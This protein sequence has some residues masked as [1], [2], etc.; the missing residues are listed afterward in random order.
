[1]LRKSG[2][3]AF[4]ILIAFLMV[5][6]A[7]ALGLGTNITIYD[8]ES[9]GSPGWH[10]QGTSPGEDEEVEPGN[11]TGQEWDLEG[12]FLN[13]TKL[14]MVGG[15]NFLTGAGGFRS[16]D[17]FID[18]D[19]DA[20]YGEDASGLVGGLNSKGNGIFPIT[21]VYG[22]DYVFDLDVASDKLDYDVYKLD[23]SSVLESVHYRI[24]DGANPWRYKE[25]GEM[26]AEDVEF[27]YF[28]WDGEGLF[29]GNFHNALMVDLGI[30]GD[31]IDDGFLAHFAIECGNDNLMGSAPAPTP[32]PATMFLLGTGLIGLAG[33]GRKKL[34]PK[35]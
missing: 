28:S 26:I 33:I 34:R 21:N 3:L 2:I 23:G 6:N 18:V 10:N 20:Q 22:Y 8:N 24:N 13:G 31:V 11:T 30:L 14:T 9:S 16:G 1:M 27:Q 32:E 5:G 12:F 7:T 19:G 29:K 35:K 15:Y 4:S 17:I 25:G